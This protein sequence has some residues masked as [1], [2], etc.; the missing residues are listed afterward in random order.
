MPKPLCIDL[1]CGLGGWAEGFLSEG[2]DLIGFDIE[3]HDYGTGGYPGQLV[4][5]DVLTLDGRQFRGKASMIVASPPCQEF[6]YMAM[7]WSRAKQIAGALREEVP[8]PEPYTGSRTIEALTRLFRACFRIAKEAGVPLVVEN[9]KGAQ[10][11]V[12]QAKANYGS[13]Y[14]WG[15]IG[16]VGS[17]IAGPAPQFGVTVQARRGGKRNPDGTDHPQGS[18][19][20]V[21]DSKQRGSK[22]DGG[23][24]FA[25]GSP[26][27]PIWP[28]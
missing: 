3:R 27:W 2:W 21:A 15:D 6:S 18:W 16:S 4:L 24:W 11:W 5:Q 14:L 20:K 26:G 12:G 10:P 28:L 23:I 19:F 9:V 22:N 7:P 8:F 13:F 17:R 25:I 1:F